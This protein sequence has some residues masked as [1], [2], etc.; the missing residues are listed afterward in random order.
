M[1]EFYSRF[2]GNSEEGGTGVGR[3]DVEDLEDDT[4][5]DPRDKDISL[6]DERHELALIKR[7]VSPKN[8]LLLTAKEALS[9]PPELELNNSGLWTRVAIPRGT[10]YGPFLGRWI[11]KPIDPRFAWEVSAFNI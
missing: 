11:N 5:Q 6:M 3:S 1:N 8:D 4:S 2:T 9:I 10:R 7:D